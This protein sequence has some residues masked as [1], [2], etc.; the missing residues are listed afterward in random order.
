MPNPT[1][2]SSKPP[3]ADSPLF[4]LLM[5]GLV[6]LVAVVAVAPRYARRQGQLQQKW[7]ARERI[8]REAADPS[9]PKATDESKTQGGADPPNLRPLFLVM[10]C[11]VAALAAALLVQR[12]R[13]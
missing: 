2:D 4:W 5:F 10:A 1:R 7:E 6:A 13:R 12:M 8:A 9:G 11:F 3:V